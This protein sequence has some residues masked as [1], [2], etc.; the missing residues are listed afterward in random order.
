MAVEL[1]DEYFPPDSGFLMLDIG[2]GAG[3]GSET[4]AQHR[5]V[6][7]VER[8]QDLALAVAQRSAPNQLSVCQGDAHQLPIG[9]AS[10]DGV[11]L[12]EVLEHV[13]DPDRVLA[14][15]HR[16]L[17]PNGSICVAVPTSY[18]ER[19][20]SRLHP[21]Y[22]RNATHV[23]IFKKSDLCRQLRQRGFS[24]ARVIA[25]NFEPAVCWLVHSILR[26]EADATG[27]V[28]EHESVEPR[29]ASAVARISA[30]R[31]IGRALRFTQRHFGKSW[32]VY[33][34][35]EFPRVRLG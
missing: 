15:A 19:V 8:E 12:L 3:G 30:T 35:K 17:K 21:R 4:Y 16:V 6:V 34:R 5:R 18:T 1:D 28:L 25:E 23:R 24:E 9:G 29:V 10:V 26:T 31:G 20:Y 32:Y 13:D 22:M 33:A 14:E 2:P 11:T 27:R 7:A